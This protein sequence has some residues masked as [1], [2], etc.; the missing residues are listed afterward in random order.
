MAQ[1]GNF[2]RSV[3]GPGQDSG[4]PM[5]VRIKKRESFFHG[6]IVTESAGVVRWENR[7]EV[8]SRCQLGLAVGLDSWWEARCS[9][10]LATM[11]VNLMA[12]RRKLVNNRMKHVHI[13][14]WI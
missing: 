4:D 8:H 1:H 10:C 5:A 2:I 3:V 6:R 14:V 13:V 9:G 12:K 7:G 11:A